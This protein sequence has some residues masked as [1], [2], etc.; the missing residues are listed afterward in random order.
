MKLM[1]LKFRKEVCRVCL[2]EWSVI[3]QIMIM[4][5]NQQQ[6]TE[7]EISISSQWILLGYLAV[8]SGIFSKSDKFCLLLCQ[9]FIYAKDYQQVKIGKGFE[10]F[11]SLY[12]VFFITQSFINL[13]D[14][15]RPLAVYLR[16]LF[17]GR[18]GR[19]QFR[20]NLLYLYSLFN[21]KNT[22]VIEI[23]Y[24]IHYKIVLEKL[25][26]SKMVTQRATF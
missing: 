21:L 14:R 10:D 13:C 6:F 24:F 17:W 20:K 4:L 11:F 5:R 12:L 18:V 9:Q 15:N 7:A 1:L 2:S 8:E 22:F 23:Y 26:Y 19:K 25:A 16:K 3:I